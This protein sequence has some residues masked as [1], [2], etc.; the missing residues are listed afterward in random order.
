[1]TNTPTR[2]SN[3]IN[4]P[5]VTVA[6]LKGGVGKSTTALM[7]SEGLAYYFGLRV[8]VLD[9]DAQSNLSQ[10]LLSER[11]VNK[12]YEDERGI[13]ASLDRFIMQL[14]KPIPNGS[15]VSWTPDEFS[16]RI[17]ANDAN[18]IYEIV[19]AIRNNNELGKVELIPAH[20][21]LRFI[22]PQL[23][24]T[25]GPDWVDLPKQLSAYIRATIA[26]M[27]GH[28][29]LVVIDCP[30]NVSA[31]CRTALSIANYI[32]TPVVAEELSF[33]GF[34]QFHEWMRNDE[35]RSWLGDD[36][37]D[38]GPRQFVVFTKFQ[39][40]NVSAAAKDKFQEQWG[41][42]RFASPIRYRSDIEKELP[43]KGHDSVSTFRGKYKPQVRQD[44]LSLCSQFEQFM[45]EKEKTEWKRVESRA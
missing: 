44:I 6:N 42:R 33:W 19:T 12:A 7:L 21:Q 14:Q 11:G 29:D 3:P 37:K 36:F 23:E 43:R 2:H 38:L 18:T 10:L 22:E 4:A 39:K 28:Y 27:R 15:K 16:N 9:F 20:F 30:P 31:L 32:V 13:C 5:I 35:T 26:P 25:P 17:V 40:N 45:S 41:D 24:R 8:L 1:M 34:K